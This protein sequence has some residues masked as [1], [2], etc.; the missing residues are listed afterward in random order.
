[1]AKVTLVPG[2][3]NL[4]GKRDKV[5]HG[6]V[7]INN[8]RIIPTCNMCN[9]K[10]GEQLLKLGC[11]SASLDRKSKMQRAKWVATK[12]CNMKLI[13]KINWINVN[14]NSSTALELS[15]INNWGLKPVLQAPNLTLMF[16]CGSRHLVSCSVLVVNL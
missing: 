10:Q 15:V 1:M 7:T 4:T 11:H 8:A 12:S 5:G 3:I 9:G 16:C 6:E 2:S 14:H 13:I